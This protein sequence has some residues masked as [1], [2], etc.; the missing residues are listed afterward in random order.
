[1]AEDC[2]ILVV[3]DDPRLRDRL[4][5]YLTGEGFRVTAACDAAGQNHTARHFDQ[6][7]LESP[8]AALYVSRSHQLC[9]GSGY[10]K[11]SGGADGGRTA[12]H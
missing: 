9:A 11:G 7:R 5:R 6:A 2:H 12:L 3:E 4:A 10:G 1:M 8:G